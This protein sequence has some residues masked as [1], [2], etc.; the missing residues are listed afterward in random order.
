MP[1]V[2]TREQFE[3]LERL[4]G[5]LRKR[6]NQL[7]ADSPNRPG[8]FNVAELNHAVH[9][10]EERLEKLEAAEL[11]RTPIGPVPAPSPF[12]DVIANQRATAAKDWRD[13]Q[14][15]AALG[16]QVEA[17]P[18][19]SWLDHFDPGVWKFETDRSCPVVGD[20][21]AEALTAAGIGVS[22]TTADTKE[23]TA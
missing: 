21:A 1:E 13:T 17:M 7:E 19:G 20:T 8:N 10:L 6:I 16:R 23:A 5:N 15:L 12:V 14:R 11:R 22:A 2:P 9:R 18:L 4:F 3:V